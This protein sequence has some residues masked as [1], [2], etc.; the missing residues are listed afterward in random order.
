MFYTNTRSPSSISASSQLKNARARSAS[1]GGGV[2]SRGTRRQ[3]HTLATSHG[4]P[5]RRESTI[6][7]K[8]VE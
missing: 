2:R 7:E 4:L 8:S 6:A 3:S 1:D 5:K